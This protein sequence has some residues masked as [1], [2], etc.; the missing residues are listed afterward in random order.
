[1]SN[2]SYPTSIDSPTNPSTSDTLATVPHHLQHGLENDAIVALETKLG[3]GASNQ[4]ASNGSFLVGSGTGATS[5]INTLT[6]P[7]ITTSLLDANNKTWI[8][9]NPAGSSAVNY[10]N[11]GNSTTGNAVTYGVAGTDGNIN[12]NITS[13]GSGKVQDNGSNLVDF[14]SSFSNFIQTGGIWTQNTGLVGAMTAATIWINGIEYSVSAIA[15][16]TFGASVDTYIDYTVGTGIVYTA[17]SNNATSPSLATN[18]VRIAIVVTGS[19]SIS[20]VNQG[21][22]EATAP[23]VSSNVLAVSDSIGNIIYPSNPNPGLLGYRKI[24]SNFSTSSTTATL[25]TGLNVTVIATGR[26]LKLTTFARDIFSTTSAGYMSW[27]IWDGTAGSGTQL[28]AGQSNPSNTTGQTMAMAMAWTTPAAGVTK[29]YTVGLLTSAGSANIE[30]A[31]LYPAFI[32][33]EN[34]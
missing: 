14:R 22:V 32:S 33:V 18:S 8:G 28:G 2:T 3:T 27:S 4:T 1:M 26:R 10:P 20:S 12:T 9:Q 29:T 13:K 7:S 17:V 6:S 23:I 11:L 15:S 21:A 34:D 24:T 31:A 25:V 19:S 5:W 30:A 16:H